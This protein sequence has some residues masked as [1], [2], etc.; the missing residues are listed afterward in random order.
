MAE[1]NTALAIPIESTILPNR[2]LSIYFASKIYH[3]ETGKI[4][5]T[6][7]T[8]FNWTA[9][10]PV[11][12]VGKVP[13][14]HQ[15]FSRLFWQH[16]YEDV[17]KADV[18]MVWARPDDNLRGALVEAGIAIGLGKMVLVV[19]ENENYGTWQYHPSVLRATD[20]EEARQI[21]RTLAL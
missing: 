19:G 6:E 15:Q 12:H 4:L 5:A 20:L 3:A 18:T 17:A 8:E 10:W 9:R 11:H 14:H 1:C 13:E 2:R 16:D 21:L 7:W